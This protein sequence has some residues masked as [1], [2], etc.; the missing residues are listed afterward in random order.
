MYKLSKALAYSGADSLAQ[1]L[2][3]AIESLE[4]GTLPL[5]QATTQGGHVDDSQVSATILSVAETERSIEA[6]AGVFFHEIVGGC[7]CGDPPVSENA[8]CEIRVSIDKATGEAEFVV[9]P[10]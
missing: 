6:R 10:D 5:A 4:P 3:R 9:C 2:K 1:A 8:S 7:S